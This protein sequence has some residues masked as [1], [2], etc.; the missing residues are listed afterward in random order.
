MEALAY[1]IAGLGLFFTGIQNLRIYLKLFTARK[2]ISKVTKYIDNSFL[3]VIWGGCIILLTQ[4][5]TAATFM[6]ISIL[7]AGLIKKKSI[8]P[9][10]IGINLFGIIPLFLLII[11]IKI[12]ILFIL[13]I[14]C[15]ILLNEKFAKYKN[16][17]GI[18]FGISL[19]FMGLYIIEIGVEPLSS[20][21]WFKEAVQWSVKSFI[22]CIV[23]GAILSFIAQTSLAVGILCIAFQQY[24]VFTVYESIIL[25]YGA[26]IGSSFLTL[27]FGYSLK[28]KAR[29]ILMFQVLYNFVG[30]AIMIPLFILDRHFNIPVIPTF[31]N[32]ITIDAGFQIVLI[33][34]TFNLIA[35]LTMFFLMP[36]ISRILNKLWPET[37]EEK[38]SSPRHLHEAAISDPITA[39]L[40]IEKEQLRM[41][42]NLEYFFELLRSNISISKLRNAQEAASDLSKEIKN[43]LHD[44][45]KQFNI[46]SDIYNS[47]DILLSIQHLYD[48]INET[49]LALG[50]DFYFMNNKK[51]GQEL[52]NI[53]IE[54]MDA[55]LKTLSEV[56]E[57]RNKQEAIFLEKMTANDSIGVFSVRNAFIEEKQINDPSIKM[58]LLSATNYCERIIWLLGRLGRVY[59]K[60]V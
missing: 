58:H 14:S 28:G 55:I 32:S 37:Y 8:F 17:A 1:V 51:F 22:L 36:M 56:A 33:F 54:G 60:N 19:I 23:I 9:M 50:H 30:V 3:G 57:S 2:L 25:I 12:A 40:L 34:F 46:N 31:I 45:S 20:S 29:Q 10:I 41:I 11:D 4:S 44:I 15:F 53:S 16:I 35:G 59:M 6:L 39:I 7:G 38:L 48:A 42:E 49:I 26:F 27:C 52:R 21:G 24:G 13:G 18:L 47:L 5:T 43:S